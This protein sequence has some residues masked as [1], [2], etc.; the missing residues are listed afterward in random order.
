[1]PRGIASPMPAGSA[2]AAINFTMFVAALSWLVCLYAIV[3]SFVPGLGVAMVLLPLDVAAVVFTF[4]DAIVLAAKLRAVNCSNIGARNL[5]SSW[6]GFGSA[7]DEKRCREI[8]A[9][10]AFMWFL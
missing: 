6:V 2:M 7:D 3:A 5:P 1:M 4:I 8:Q 10:T 9:S